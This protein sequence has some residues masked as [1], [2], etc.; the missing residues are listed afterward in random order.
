M[1]PYDLVVW[2]PNLAQSIKE[3]SFSNRQFMEDFHEE[4]LYGTQGAGLKRGR[5]KSLSGPCDLVATY[6]LTFAV[7]LPQRCQT[8]SPSLPYSE[9]AVPSKCT[10]IGL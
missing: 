9:V 10:N 2:Q 7:P 6:Y 1:N 4:E 8:P 3:D 5:W